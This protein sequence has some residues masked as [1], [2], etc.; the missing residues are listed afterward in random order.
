VKRSSITLILL[1]VL[2]LTLSFFNPRDDSDSPTQR[3]G[4]R[5]HRDHLTG[6]EYFTTIFGGITPRLRADG[7]QVCRKEPAP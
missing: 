6:C 7:T 2:I 3:S 5:I 4:L 1:A